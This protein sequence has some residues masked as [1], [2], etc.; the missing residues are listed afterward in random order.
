ML[1]V[2]STSTRVSAFCS[3]SF[4]GKYFTLLKGATPIA[5][6]RSMRISPTGALLKYSFVALRSSSDS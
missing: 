1:C 5:C 6:E 3:A 4:T 2:A